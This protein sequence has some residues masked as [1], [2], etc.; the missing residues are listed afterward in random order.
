MNSTAPDSSDG[1][2]NAG[3]ESVDP[4]PADADTAAPAGG[5]SRRTILINIVRTVLVVLVVAAAIWQLWTNWADVAHT[6]AELQWHR[7]LLSLVAV[8]VGIACST[9]SWQLLLDDLGK[10]IGVG[11]GAQIFLVGQLGKYLPGSIWAYVLQIELGRKAGLARAR[12]FAATL[13]SV[14][15]AVVAAL[16]AGA[17]AI[18]VLVEQDSRLD[19]LP[20]LYLT[21]PIALI[22]LIPAVLTRIVRFGFKILRRPRPDHPVTLNVVVRSLAFALGSYVAFGVHLWLLADTREGLTLSPLALCIGTM[23]IAM[24]AGLVFFLL[25]SGVGAREFVIIA[26]LTPFVGPGAATAY[27]AVSRVMF[28]V[29]DLATAGS[30]AGLAVLARRRRGEYQGD[31][32]IAPEHLL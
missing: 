9:M 31:A 24:L 6:I 25:P 2:T 18:P 21:L 13:F 28:I 3:A 1:G 29:A 22:F 5:K 7:T 10:P 12:V 11:R 17:L 8:V 27:A 16:I 23:G 15:I 19:W 32:G 20:W 30:A 4:T 26:A 14:I